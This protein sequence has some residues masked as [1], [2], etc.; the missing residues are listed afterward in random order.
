MLRRLWRLL[1]GRAAPSAL[2]GFLDSL[3][4]GFENRRAGLADQISSADALAF[5]L[6][7]YD[8]ELDRLRETI[9]VQEPALSEPERRD[10]FHRVDD[11]VRKV[12]VPAY[13][14]LAAPLTRRERNDFY[15]TPGPLHGLER[16]GWAVA[17]IALGGF[18][19]WAPFI[20]VWEK[21]WVLPFALAGL[22]FPD[23]RRY[24]ALRRYQAELNGLVAH[25]NDEVWRMEVSYLTRESRVEEESA[26]EG[27]LEAATGEGS[28]SPRTRLREGE[29]GR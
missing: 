15:L 13:V 27:R 9:R 1:R 10:F 7:L 22:V 3:I 21:E 14:R 28:T 26:L 25:G 19:V 8:K 16:A 18:V 17:G 11:L 2:S 29:G 6:D 23:L 4:Q 20:P 5:F 12:I 24:F